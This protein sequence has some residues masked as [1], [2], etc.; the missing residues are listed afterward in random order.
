LLGARL[1][2]G[3][4]LQGP[5]R[6]REPTARISD[7]TAL[8]DKCYAVLSSPPRTTQFV[9]EGAR[10]K[11]L[12]RAI[13]AQVGLGANLPEDAIYPLN[14]ADETGKPLDGASK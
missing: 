11:W 12:E 1:A 2:T 13:V 3:Q 14:L 5:A 9:D 4:S 7:S 6:S 8:Q 10:R